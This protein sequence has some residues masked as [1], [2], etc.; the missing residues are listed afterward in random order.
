MLIGVISDTHGLLRPEAVRALE[1]SERIVHAG[2]VGDP[3]ILEALE[4]I[5]PVWAVRGNVDGGALAQDLPATE[6]VPAGETDLYLLHDLATLDLDPAAAGFGAVIYGHSH[7]PSVE[8]RDG[9]LFLNPD[10]A[11]PRRFKL[12]VTVARLTVSGSRLEA[13]II[14]LDV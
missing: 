7:K 14:E 13:K 2:D 3:A 4:R 9:V 10:A 6:V 11:G 8:T 5:A 1:G 12:P